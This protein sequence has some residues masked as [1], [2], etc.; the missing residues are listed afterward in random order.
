MLTYAFIVVG[1]FS[2]F[3]EH[4]ADLAACLTESGKLDAQRAADFRRA[5][6]IVCAGARE[7]RLTQWLHPPLA[8]RLNHLDRALTLG[9]QP[10]CGRAL[11]RSAIALC[12]AYLAC[13]SAI[14]L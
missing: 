7:S 6:T 10:S 14:A 12:L 9:C 1:R 2:R 11:R 8:E 5:L 3:L 4:D 13:A